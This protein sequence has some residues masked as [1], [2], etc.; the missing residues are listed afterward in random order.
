MEKSA[1][2]RPR[3]GLRP[4][5]GPRIV[6]RVARFLESPLVRLT[7]LAGPRTVTLGAGYCMLARLFLGALIHLATVFLGDAGLIIGL[8][9]AF[10]ALLLL[11]PAVFCAA[12]GFVLWLVS[13][14]TPRRK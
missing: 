9:L 6:I 3:H 14:V 2:D 5:P 11:F 10:L 12:S 13:M 8:P 4:R 1:L 7:W